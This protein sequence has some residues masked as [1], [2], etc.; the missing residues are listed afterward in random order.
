M[1]I[2]KI[3]KD[4]D[5]YYTTLWKEKLTALH[6]RHFGHNPLADIDVEQESILKS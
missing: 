1:L 6:G 3:K 2:N 5:K 4:H